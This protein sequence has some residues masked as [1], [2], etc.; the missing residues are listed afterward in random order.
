M[1]KIFNRLDYLRNKLQESEEVGYDQ[2]LPSY[3]SEYQDEIEDLVNS[4]SQTEREKYYETR[5]K[6]T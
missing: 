6:N 4:L 1:N 3:F 2:D 5:I